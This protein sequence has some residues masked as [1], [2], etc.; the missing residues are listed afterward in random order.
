[1]APAASTTDVCPYRAA[2]SALAAR[3]VKVRP[4]ADAR[5]TLK[6]I[7]PNRNP[8]TRGRPAPPAELLIPPA[9]AAPTRLHGARAVV[10]HAH[11]QT[12]TRTCAKMLADAHMRA[13]KCAHKHSHNHAWTPHIR[14]D[15]AAHPRTH[16][17][18]RARP[19]AHAHTDRFSDTPT[20]THPHAHTLSRPARTHKPTLMRTHT[21]H[22]RACA[23][24]CVC[25]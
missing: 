14:M 16:A 11:A 23:C 3:V 6:P 13:H 7:A 19:R 9:P 15:A 1:M 4:A 24:V 18:A 5:M 8:R 21:L 17:D 22:G 2:H 10:P 12:H 25:A 20:H